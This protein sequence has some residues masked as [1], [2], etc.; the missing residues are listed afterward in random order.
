M[1]GI[2]EKE[3]KRLLEL[4]R[5]GFEGDMQEE[6][7]LLGELSRIIGYFEQLQEVDT[8]DTEPLSGGS[9][10]VSVPREDSTKVVSD[11]ERVQQRNFISEQF[12]D[13]EHGYVRVPPVF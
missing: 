6:Q 5:I 10:H 2:H 13:Q 4:S 7:K 9:M 11:E 3:L 8:S 1:P 12:P